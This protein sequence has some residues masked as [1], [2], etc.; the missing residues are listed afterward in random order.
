M[1]RP[2]FQEDGG[3]RFQVENRAFEN[4][5]PQF[6]WGLQAGFYG[7]GYG[8]SGEIRPYPNLPDKFLLHVIP[9]SGPG[10]SFPPRI[11][12]I[13]CIR[14]DIR[15]IN[16]KRHKHIHGY[17]GICVFLPS[18]RTWNPFKDKIVDLLNM[19]CD[20][21]V[22]HMIYIRTGRWPGE[23]TPHDK[24]WLKRNVGV[25]DL[26]ICGSGGKFKKCCLRLI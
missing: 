10:D 20:W 14:P 15:I 18:D 13:F 9:D 6:K 11:P 21:L 23:E 8:W 2:W 25:N 12:P 16:G 5:F 1:K 26:C 24:E 3:A 22:K 4:H 7:Q 17:G 19:G